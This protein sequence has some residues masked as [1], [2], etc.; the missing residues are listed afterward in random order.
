MKRWVL[1]ILVPALLAPVALA[2]PAEAAGVFCGGHRATI[3][4]TAAGETIRGTSGD[5]VINGRGGND[6]IFGGRGRDIICGAR[7]RDVVIGGPGDDRL[8]GNLDSYST[9]DGE[10]YLW[11]DAL[12]GGPGSDMLSPGVD[13]RTADVITPDILRWSDAPRAVSIDMRTG[14]AA[15]YG[16][17]HFAL[18]GAEIFG[19][20]FGD[21][22]YGNASGNF[23]DGWRG[24]DTIY[25]GPGNDN[26]ITDGLGPGSTGT[27]DTVIAGRGN[28]AVDVTDGKDYVSGG[29]GNDQLRAYRETAN[30]TVIRGGDGNDLILYALGATGPG[31]D[32]A[33]LAA[34]A[35]HDQLSLITSTAN[36]THA[37]ATGSWNMTSG[38]MVFTIAT[39]I[40]LQAPEFEDGFLLDR[41]TWTITGTDAD[42]FIRFDFPGAF[43]AGADGSFAG[44]GGDD[45]FQGGPRADTFNGGPGTDRSLGM[46]AGDDTCIAVETFD[47][48]DC[49]HVS[50]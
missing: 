39:P 11:G 31:A 48:S 32:R 24:S 4:G 41:G 2:S 5:D 38:A 18:T 22:I 25:A 28:D 36:P 33:I 40:T 49:E 35:G 17:D 34:G 21:H 13:T 47:I 43:F 19:S 8:Y 15:G 29:P 14:G 20:A 9:V 12:L 42:N 26:I 16:H 23:I 3:V 44:L 45:T 46:G 6:V 7:G 10:T 37:P 27:S 50:A 30:G 1:T